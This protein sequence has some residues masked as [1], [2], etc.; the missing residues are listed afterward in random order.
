[1]GIFIVYIFSHYLKLIPKHLPQ[2]KRV[3]IINVNIA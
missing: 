2:H 3:L 1:M